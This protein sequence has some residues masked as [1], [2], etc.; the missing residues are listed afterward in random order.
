MSFHAI[1]HA[2]V[3]QAIFI[4]VQIKHVD[5]TA[6]LLVYAA[7]C[8]LPQS[9]LIHQIAEPGRQLEVFVPGVIG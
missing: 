6:D 1:V 2:G 7:L 5:F 4:S 3:G 9:P 8:F